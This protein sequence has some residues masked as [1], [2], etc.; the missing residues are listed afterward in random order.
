MKERIRQRSSSLWT[1]APVLGVCAKISYTV[2]NW[3]SFYE[4]EGKLNKQIVAAER[5][6]AAIGPYS[7]AV[8]MG[9]LVF[10]AGQLGL[11]PETKRL[12]GPDI[13]S[14]TRQVLENLGAILEASGSCL[15]HVLKT[16][17]FLQDI[18]EF[19]Q[20]N[21]VYGRFF[22]ERP[23]ARSTVQVAALPMGA[24]VEIEAVAEVCDCGTKE[25]DPCNCGASHRPCC[26]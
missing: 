2:C 21:E 22:K 13:Q 11:V 8:R 25:G 17:V 9:S 1:S 20:M 23:P 3:E 12:V 14:Q 7:Q 16:T 10:A 19:A 26:E 4:K 24:R 5:A 6:P 15:E 18:K